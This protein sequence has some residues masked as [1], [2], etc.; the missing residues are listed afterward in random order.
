[1]ADLR[2][3]AP[4]THS[5]LLKIRDGEIKAHG[6]LELTDA[7]RPLL[8]II[9]NTFAPLMVQNQRA[10]SAAHAAGQR[11]F[12]E[13]AFDRNEALYDGE[14]LVFSIPRGCKNPFRYGCGAT[15]AKPG[16]SWGVKPK[17]LWLDIV[18][19]GEVFENRPMGDC[20]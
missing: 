12:N 2:E 13:A 1:M 19:G 10:Y 9:M 3:R 16:S 15:C 11:R 7:L 4:L 6:D 20:L 14:L 18:P 17:L 5:W 8:E